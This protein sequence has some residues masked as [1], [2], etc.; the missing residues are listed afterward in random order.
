[1]SVAGGPHPKFEILDM[2]EIC[3]PVGVFRSLFTGQHKLLYSCDYS[4][5]QEICQRRTNRCERD[6]GC[7]FVIVLPAHM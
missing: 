3:G 4:I 6:S 5:S 2:C 1:M 7:F